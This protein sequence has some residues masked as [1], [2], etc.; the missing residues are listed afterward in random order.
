MI[1]STYS[2][3]SLDFVLLHETAQ[4]VN[5]VEYKSTSVEQSSQ[6]MALHPRIARSEVYSTVTAS[7]PRGERRRESRESLEGKYTGAA[8][9]LR[10]TAV[11]FGNGRSRGGTQIE[12]I[13]I[14]ASVTRESPCTCA[15]NSINAG[16]TRRLAERR[17]FSRRKYTGGDEM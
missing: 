17:H 10:S 11:F 15:A 1:E 4:P 9:K 6:K 7:R 16:P 5:S 8:A 13:Y 14:V 2:L 12:S 3:R